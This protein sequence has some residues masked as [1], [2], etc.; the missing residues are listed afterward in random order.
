AYTA[1]LLGGEVHDSGIERHQQVEAAAIERKSLHF[2]LT[3]ESGNVL[4]RGVHH[5]YVI[6]DLHLLGNAAHSQM[7]IGGR[8]FTDDQDDSAADLLGEACLLCPELVVTDG[9]R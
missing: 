4:R 5:R 8:I 7:Q 6:G 9:K 1:S 2:F 3:H